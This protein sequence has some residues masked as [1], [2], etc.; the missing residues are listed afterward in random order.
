[1]NKFISYLL[2][3][4][5]LALN[6]GAAVAPASLEG[7]VIRIGI[8]RPGEARE[9][10][11]QSGGSCYDI[12][13]FHFSTM[14][15]IPL[16]IGTYVYTPGPAEKATLTFNFPGPDAEFHSTTYSLVFE[17][18]DSGTITNPSLA[19]IYFAVRELVDGGYA[20][21]VSARSL[22]NRDTPSIA[23]FIIHGSTPRLCLIRAVGPSLKKFGVKAAVADVSLDIHSEAGV[24]AE[25]QDWGSSN[26][27]ALEDAFARCGAFPLERDSKDTALLVI[28]PP[29]NYTALARSP[30]Q[31]EV[32]VE[33][34]LVP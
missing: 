19:G 3:L 32:L 4:A 11:L 29:G 9:T 25:N 33:V 20:S 31:G 10:L 26:T 7:R 23:G 30:E 8:G 34:Y 2:L 21:N 13:H 17:D 24:I 16:Q 6:A 15:A 22:V 28:L 18:A 27:S 12:Y 5:L 14:M 1:M